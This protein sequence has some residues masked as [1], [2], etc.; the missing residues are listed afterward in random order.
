MVEPSSTPPIA[1]ETLHPSREDAL[2]DEELALLRKLALT[3]KRWWQEPAVLVAAMA[4]LLSL[5]TAIISAWAAYWNGLHDQQAQLEK[6]TLDIKD[7]ILKEPEIKE[8]YKNNPAVQSYIGTLLNTQERAIQRYAVAIALNLGTNASS[9]ELVILATESDHAGNVTEAISLDELAVSAAASPLDKS[10]ALR[11]LAGLQIRVNASPAMLAA[12]NANFQRAVDLE[13][14]Y[15]DLK[16]ESYLR[17]YIKTIVELSW[18]GALISTNCE[19][20]HSHFEKAQSYLSSA[21]VADRQRLMDVLAA[22]NIPLRGD[23]ILTPPSCPAAPAG[24]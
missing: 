11:N 14:E 10:W 21:S 23:T 8:E 17:S 19:E 4:F 15:P 16:E 3:K 20:A 18:G 7:L 6:L 2:R 1:A 5:V 13:A 9:G 24:H 22:G 12:G